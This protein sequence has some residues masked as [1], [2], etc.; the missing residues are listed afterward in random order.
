[1]TPEDAFL[2]DILSNPDDPAPRLIYSDWLEDQGDPRA[3]HIR[4]GCKVLEARAGTPQRRVLRELFRLRLTD[5]ARDWAEVEGLVLTWRGVVAVFRYR[6]AEAITWCAGR[7]LPLRSPELNP[8]EMTEFEGW[9]ERVQRV[10]LRRS[11]ELGRI[12][13]TPRWLADDSSG[14]KLL[15]YLPAVAISEP[16]IERGPVEYLDRWNHP[17]W[18]CWLVYGEEPDPSAEWGVS[19]GGY[20][21]TWVPNHLVADINRAMVRHPRNSVRWAEDFDR[22]LIRHLRESGLV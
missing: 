12:G 18:D 15:V 6:L 17:A 1:M 8:G 21:L 22:Y 19:A 20:V 14:G 11:Q 13:K 4:D 9:G 5:Q 3:E 16:S 2:L 7:A 10:V